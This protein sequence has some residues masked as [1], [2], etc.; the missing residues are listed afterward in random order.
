MNSLFINKL[1]LDFIK[2]LI[3]ELKGENPKIEKTLLAATSNVN[4]DNILYNNGEN[5]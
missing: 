1:F 5:I 2:S 3:E 4:I